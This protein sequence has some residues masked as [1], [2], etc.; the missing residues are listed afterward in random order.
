MIA[1]ALFAAFIELYGI[2]RKRPFPLST[3]SIGLGVVLPVDASI[4][5]FIGA[6]FFWWQER[7]HKTPGTPG[8]KLWVDSVEPICAGLI[9]GA[10]LVGI[11]DAIVGVLPFMGQ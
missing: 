6:L 2:I 5:M 8:H 9:A 4:G 11:A 3:V 10:A 1:A 7:R